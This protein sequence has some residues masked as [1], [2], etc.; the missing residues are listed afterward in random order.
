MP[1]YEWTTCQVVC[2]G[3]GCYKEA[4]SS[5][6]ELQAQKYAREDGWLEIDGKWFCSK[7]CATKYKRKVA[8]EQRARK[9]V[10]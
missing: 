5:E 1:I 3:P 8:R 2:D 7:D 6:S 10:R 9:V 4:P